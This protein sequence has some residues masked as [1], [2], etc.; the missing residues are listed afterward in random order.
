MI[1]KWNQFNESKAEKPGEN[2]T[3]SAKINLSDE[4]V[5]AFTDNPSLQK[6]ISDDKV[7]LLGNVAWYWEDDMGTKGVMDQYLEIPGTV[8]EEPISENSQWVKIPKY[9]FVIFNRSDESKSLQDKLLNE[10][11]MSWSFSSGRMGEGIQNENITYIYSNWNFDGNLLFENTNRFNNPNDG[12]WLRHW[13]DEVGI[14][15]SLNRYIWDG[16]NLITI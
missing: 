14:D 11:D 6:L 12:V 4:D 7:A 10:L 16:E 3:G 9:P 8:E 5:N 15:I 2:V 13:K 1:K